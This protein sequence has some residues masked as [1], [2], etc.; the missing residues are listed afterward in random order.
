M[1][2]IVKLSCKTTLVMEKTDYVQSAALG[3]WVKAGAADESN[4]VS[5][6]SHFIEHMSSRE[7]ISVR[8]RKSLQTW[9]K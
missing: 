7:P 8:Q 2:K 6:V 5:G 3:I 1:V 9:T 4:D